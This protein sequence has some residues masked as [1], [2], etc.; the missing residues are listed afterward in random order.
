M[1]GVRFSV[2]MPALQFSGA[3]CGTA[4]ALAMCGDDV[5]VRPAIENKAF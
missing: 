5:L 2:C 4:A 3:R 1:C